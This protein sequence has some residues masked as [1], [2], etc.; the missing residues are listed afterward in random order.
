MDALVKVSVVV[1]VYNTAPYL[2]QCLDSL[3]GQSLADIEIICVDDGSTDDS[4]SILQE[5]AERDARIKVL[6]QQNQFAGVA[7]NNGMTAAC[8]EYIMFCDS[9]DF[10]ADNALELMYEKCKEDRADICVCAGERYYEQ[11]GLTVAAPGY[12]EIKRVPEKLPFN[13]SDNAEHLF[14]FT[15]I[16][17]FNKM[18]RLDFL[19]EHHLQYATT[20][21]GEDVEI[22]ALALWYADRITVVKT[23][24]VFYRI[25]RPDSL[26]GTLSQAALDPLQAWMRVWRAIGSELGDAKRSFDCKFLGVARHTL[27][28]VRSGVA[29]DQ[30]FDYLKNEAVDAMDLRI[31]RDGYYYTP[32]YNS[33]VSHLRDDGCED[34]KVYMLYAAS[35]D[36]DADEARKLDFRRRLREAEQKKIQAEAALRSTEKHL[37][38]LK[39]K[40]AKVEWVYRLGSGTKNVL[41]KLRSIPSG[42]GDGNQP[43]RDT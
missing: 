2:A 14:S 30:C 28:N 35:Q 1:P 12:L 15:T 36:L 13:R 42:D 39:R 31:R 29:F 22:C 27:R 32:W 10:M 43:H 19:R 25:D 11:L 8:G 37:S 23:P 18:F 7:R 3:I 21:N 26:V 16:M 9:D 41:R 33:F 6:S 38:E 24:L 40:F 5:Y 20:R 4:P 17:M 34:F